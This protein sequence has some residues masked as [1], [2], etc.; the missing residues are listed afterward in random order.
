M[1]ERGNYE[2]IGKATHLYTKKICVIKVVE[3][4]HFNHDR[5]DWAHLVWSPVLA[6]SSWSKILL[7]GC[8][9]R[10]RPSLEAP[11]D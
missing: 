4:N 5:G 10:W 1:K 6:E 3:H 11:S 2:T 7:I 8:G 9:A